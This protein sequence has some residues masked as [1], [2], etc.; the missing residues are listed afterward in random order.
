MPILETDMVAKTVAAMKSKKMRGF[1]FQRIQGNSVRFVC[2]GERACMHCNV[3]RG[4]S[5]YVNFMPD[6]DMMYHCTSGH[7]EEYEDELIGQ[8]EPD[9]K[10]I[11]VVDM[12]HSSLL[13]FE[14]EIIH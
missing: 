1:S 2:D 14:P 13:T 8:W 7:C 4:N 12:P 11:G 6:S 3:H 5:C 9:P 10:T